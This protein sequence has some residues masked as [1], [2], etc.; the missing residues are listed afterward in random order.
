MS[1]ATSLGVQTA[2]FLCCLAVV[3]QLQAQEDYGNRLGR[4]EIGGAVY[5]AGGTNIRMEAVHP[6]MQEVVY[7]AGT[8]RGIPAPVGL[9]QLRPRA[10]PAVP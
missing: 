7:T 9:Y 1:G 8:G 4:P 10:L 5:Y 3:S 2:F 6:S